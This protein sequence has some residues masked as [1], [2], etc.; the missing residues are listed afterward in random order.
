MRLEGF[1]SAGPESELSLCFST[2]ESCSADNYGNAIFLGSIQRSAGVASNVNVSFDNSR[3][4]LQNMLLSRP[5]E[6]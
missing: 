2:T 6:P 5:S 3:Y 1:V 4:D